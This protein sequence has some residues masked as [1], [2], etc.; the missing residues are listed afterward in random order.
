[1]YTEKEGFVSMKT[2][3]S[4]LSSGWHATPGIKSCS[5]IE[6]PSKKKG[7]KGGNEDPSTV[8]CKVRIPLLF[9]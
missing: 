1:M 5:E 3:H 8:I 7:D 6:C 9:Q 2:A 4:L